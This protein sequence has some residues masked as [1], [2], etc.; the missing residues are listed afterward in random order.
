MR[1]SASR[2]RSRSPHVGIS[3]FPGA[4]HFDSAGVDAG[5]LTGS[6]LVMHFSTASESSSVH[7]NAAPATIGPD[8]RGRGEETRGAA[9]VDPDPGVGDMVGAARI[10]WRAS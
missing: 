2:A 10:A 9:R 1:L 3:I 8:T 7:P 4:M 5:A 6:Q